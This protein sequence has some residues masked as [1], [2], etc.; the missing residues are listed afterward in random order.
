MHMS[1]GAS[2]WPSLEEAGAECQ[3]LNVRLLRQEQWG[4]SSVA[5]PPIKGQHGLSVVQSGCVME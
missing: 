2:T 4:R 1:R 3:R 5:P